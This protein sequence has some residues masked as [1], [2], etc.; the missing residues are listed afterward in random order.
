ML[1]LA[2]LSTV[3]C[4]YGD[5]DTVPLIFFHISKHHRN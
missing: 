5:S 4:L 1:P 2:K 3:G